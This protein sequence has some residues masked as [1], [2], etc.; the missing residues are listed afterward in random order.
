MGREI[1]YQST[2]TDASVAG[3]RVQR[4]DSPE[5]SNEHDNPIPY[6]FWTS[7]SHVEQQR[8]R[9]WTRG[10]STGNSICKCD[11]AFR[12][13]GGSSW[14]PG[15]KWLRVAECTEYKCRLWCRGV[16]VKRLQ[17]LLAYHNAKHNQMFSYIIMVIINQ[18]MSL[19]INHACAMKAVVKISYESLH[20]WWNLPIHGNEDAAN[21]YLTELDMLKAPCK[22]NKEWIKS[23]GF[24]AIAQLWS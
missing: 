19:H 18:V 4:C 22:T 23:H 8:P 16:F 7:P 1:V 2:S 13:P 9:F 17:S 10:R 14:W 24:I 15:I 12:E 11:Y 3:R 20:E 21:N 5:K 6:I